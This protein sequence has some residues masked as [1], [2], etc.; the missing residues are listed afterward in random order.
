[1]NEDKY[2]EYYFIYTVLCLYRHIL[3]EAF[4]SSRMST[5]GTIRI[6]LRAYVFVS[7]ATCLIKLKFFYVLPLDWYFSFF[8]TLRN[9]RMDSWIYLRNSDIRKLNLVL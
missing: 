4:F 8:K 7:M 3:L 1:M 6:T 2:K 5:E 9:S